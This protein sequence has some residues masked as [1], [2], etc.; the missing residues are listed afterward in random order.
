M[1]D[2]QAVDESLGDEAQDRRVGHREHLRVLDP[3]ACERV[4]VEEAAVL[5]GDGVEVEELRPPASSVQ[6]GLWSST[7]MWLGT[8]STTRPSP[9]PASATSSGL[10]TEV[11][12]HRRRVDDVVAVRRPRTG[13]EH[14]REVEVA[15]AQIGQVRD[16]AARRLEGEVGSELEPVG[17]DQRPLAVMGRHHR[18]ALAS[19]RAAQHQQRPR[20][21]GYDA[22]GRRGRCRTRRAR[23]CSARASSGGRTARRQ[24]EGHGSRSGR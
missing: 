12:R 24:G 14:R 7:A 5:P 13:L 19:P 3:H 10:T 16:E 20:V 17:R 4:D 15:D 11:G 23:P 6:N 9:A 18:R 2:A 1:V 22:N 21:D 8:M